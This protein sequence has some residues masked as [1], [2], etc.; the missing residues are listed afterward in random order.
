MKARHFTYAGAVLLLGAIIWLA[1]R[2]RTP[3]IAPMVTTDL[4]EPR[5]F[6]VGDRA[7][8]RDV[9]KQTTSRLA[10]VFTANTV[11][12]RSDPKTLLGR[13]GKP[14]WTELA[15]LRTEDLAFLKAEY[16]SNTNLLQKEVLTW[17]LGYIGDAE[18]VEL[19][20]KTLLSD[21]PGKTLVGSELGIKSNEVSVMRTTLSAL[22]FLGREHDSAIKFLL[23]GTEPGFW[24]GQLLWTSSYGED[25]FSLL[26]ADCIQSLSLSTRPEVEGLL[27]N[28][29]SKP[30]VDTTVND[31]EMVP[32]WPAMF[33]K[34]RFG[35]RFFAATDQT[36]FGVGFS[37]TRTSSMQTAVFALGHP[38]LMASN[39]ANGGGKKKLKLS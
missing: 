21:Y 11:T 37:R 22:G 19:L 3:H 26:A 17:A 8:T 36:D 38:A 29:K 23:D 5:L 15:G 13:M 35:S 32:V 4:S 6:H 16:V 20:Q 7:S 25:I 27:N 33:I 39:G 1:L 34:L 2:A 24:K 14:D 12:R 9:P 18:T 10:N 28:L 30:L 31:P